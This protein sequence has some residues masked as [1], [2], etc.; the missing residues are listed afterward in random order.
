[1]EV[2]NKNNIR[3][4]LYILLLLVVF[5]II[6]FIFKNEISNEKLE[7]NNVGL[8]DENTI[9][10]TPDR[11]IYKN[12]NNEYIIINS[13]TSA[14]TQIYSEL[15]NRITNTIEG[16]VYSEDE[17]SQMQNKGTFIEFDYNS[18]SKN[19][20]FILEEKEIGIIKRFSDGG[21]VIQTSLSNKDKLIKKIENLTKDIS[22]KYDFNTEYNYNSENKLSKVANDLK[23]SQTK[24]AGVYQ[25]VIE[26]DENE[27]NAIL[28]KLNFKT[29]HEMPKVD[30]NKQSVIVTVS[31]YEIKDIQKN[32]GNIKYELGKFLDEYS[33][34]IFIV[35]KVV[36]S[37]CIY[38]NT[39][40]DEL[41]VSKISIN[42]N[43]NGVE[44]YVQNGKYYAN[45][46]N[47]KTEI[48]SIEIA[49]DI[50]EE[51]T[52]KAKYQY[53]SWKSEFY[54]GESIDNSI[55][56]ELIL[57]LDDISRLYHWRAEWQN[58]EYEG[59]TMWKIR[60][61]DK[62]DPLTSLYI[63]VDAINGEIIGAG[64]SGD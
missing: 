44:Y 34:N 22:T 26:Y 41:N 15:Y 8:V 6:F 25:Q 53:Q 62:N 55:S 3:V 19:Y 38:F 48:I 64:A 29:S 4:I 39:N 42:D 5:S 59:K 49:S 13:G 24:V 18:K 31:R 7:K 47:T 16:K 28:K 37:K 20:V 27:Y 58:E 45:I 36:N 17:I 30:F 50:A 10:P 9:L 21:Q 40:V 35:S 60:L 2:K 54:R 12:I 52:K 43:K 14:Y 51:E 57:G 61:F 56:G 1:M 33:V 11:I 23:L 63:Y 32:I 46:N